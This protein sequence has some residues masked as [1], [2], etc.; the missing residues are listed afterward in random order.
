MPAP[1]DLPSL[2][3]HDLA[4]FMGVFQASNPTNGL[5]TGALY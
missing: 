5:L 4:K 1:S 2:T 3:S